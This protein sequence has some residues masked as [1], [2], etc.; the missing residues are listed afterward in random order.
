MTIAAD[1]PPRQVWPEEFA[2]KYRQAGYWTGETFGAMLHRLA[3]THGDRVAVVDGAERI[4]YAQLLA[5]AAH[6][7]GGYLALGLTPGD[8]VLVQLPNVAGFFPAVF[9]L[10]LAGL[11]PVYAL[12]AHRQTELVH[13][14][15]RSGARAMVIADR[16]EGFDYRPLARIVLG[17]VPAIEHLIVLGEAEEHI[18]FD[19]FGRAGAVLPQVDPSSVAF[20]QISGGSTGL[21]KLIPRTHDDYIYSFTASGPICGMGPDSVYLCALP[22]AHNFPMSSPGHFGTLAAGGRVVMAPNPAPETCFC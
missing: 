16:H 1:E 15:R 12:P 8:R 19:T 7:A 21:S 18:A 5:R 10:F 9:G 4:T 22:A 13:F 11:V 6:A 2:R 14:A 20:L 17:E 3:A